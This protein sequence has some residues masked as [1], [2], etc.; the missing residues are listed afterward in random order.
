MQ[1]A[2]V[3]RPAIQVS[4]IRGVVVELFAIDGAAIELAAGTDERWLDD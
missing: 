3:E 1:P 4:A 2:V